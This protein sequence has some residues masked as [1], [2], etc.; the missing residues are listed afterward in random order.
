VDKVR[1]SDP[2]TRQSGLRHL[3]D[4]VYAVLADDDR[5]R[6]A[7]LLDE[8]SAFAALPSTFFRSLRGLRDQYNE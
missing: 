5:W 8:V 1:A 3:E 6:V 7:F 4:A 2:V